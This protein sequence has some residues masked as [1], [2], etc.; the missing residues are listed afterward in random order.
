M[1]KLF[2]TKQLDTGSSG[3]P[4]ANAELLHALRCQEADAIWVT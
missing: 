1:F 4:E 3:T 2:F